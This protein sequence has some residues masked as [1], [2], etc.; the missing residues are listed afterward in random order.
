MKKSICRSS[1]I[2]GT[3]QI[4]SKRKLLHFKKG[5]KVDF[6]TK[7]HMKEEVMTMQNNLIVKEAA[8]SKEIVM[9]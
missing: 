5:R 9:L 1:E 3:G 6:D 4:G 2:F 7:R 8:M